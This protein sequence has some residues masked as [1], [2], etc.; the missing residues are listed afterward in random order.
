MARREK[1][2]TRSFILSDNIRRS[3]GRQDAVLSNDKPA[4]AVG[5]AD[6]ED[7]L[8]RLWGEVPSIATDD[9]RGAFR[10]DRI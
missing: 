7:R 5:R 4:D 3:R 8:H 6:L 10:I 2:T 1:D 9:K